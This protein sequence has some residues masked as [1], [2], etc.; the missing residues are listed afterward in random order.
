ML[1]LLFILFFSIIT[2]VNNA[3]AQSIPPDASIISTEGTWT[4]SGPNTVKSAELNGT[5]T[6]ADGIRLFVANG[7]ELYLTVSSDGATYHRDTVNHSWNYF[8][9][10]PPTSTVGFCSNAPATPQT[11][12]AGLHKLAFCWNEKDTNNNPVVASDW[13]ATINGSPLTVTVT[14]L[15]SPLDVLGYEYETNEVN[16]PAGTYDISVKVIVGTNSAV[17][18]STSVVASG[19]VIVIPQAPSNPFVR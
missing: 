19:T 10:Q 8:G 2:N 5:G 9:P 6:G 7:N 15:S 4:L 17:G 16:L 3:N 13:S 12:M 1:V 18:N 14:K 11:I